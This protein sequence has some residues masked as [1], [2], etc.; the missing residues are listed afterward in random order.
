[1]LWLCGDISLHLSFALVVKETPLPGRTGDAPATGGFSLI[2]KTI[3]ARLS[4]FVV[5][6]T[7]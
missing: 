6:I 2:F 5:G 1:M 4:C 7:K 3:E